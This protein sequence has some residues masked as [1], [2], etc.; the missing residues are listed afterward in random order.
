MT[1]TASSATTSTRCVDPPSGVTVSCECINMQSLALDGHLSSFSVQTS[2][3]V[4]L[5]APLP[6]LHATK[7]LK[8]HQRAEKAI[9][10]PSP[11]QMISNTGSTSESKA[12]ERKKKQG[13]N[14][15][16]FS[17]SKLFFFSSKQCCKP[18]EWPLWVKNKVQLI[19][20]IES[21]WPLGQFH[22]KHFVHYW[23]EKLVKQQWLLY[24]YPVIH[25]VCERRSAP[26]SRRQ[27]LADLRCSVML[28]IQ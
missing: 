21:Q 20:V 10:S 7:W 25:T 16:C 19:C 8:E 5:I 1:V 26:P 15:L 17:S 27:L 14:I 11:A 18:Q 23:G 13:E 2:W 24:I 4:C 9:T 3:A 28:I 6:S 22:I 12:I